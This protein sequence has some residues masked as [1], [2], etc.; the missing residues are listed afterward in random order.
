MAT[1][2]GW[3]SIE[4]SGKIWV[5]ADSQE[6]AEALMEKVTSGEIE[7]ES[8]PGLQTKTNNYDFDFG[9][10]EEEES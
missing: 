10:L 6:E 4:Q 2:V 9:E 8:L 3:Y 5:D 1:F 7:M